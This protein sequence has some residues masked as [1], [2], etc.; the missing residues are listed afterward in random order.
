M[1][2]FSSIS[3]TVSPTSAGRGETV[4]VTAHLKDIVCD[5]KNVLINIPQYGLTEIM[6]EQDENTYVLSYMIPWDV[7]SGS[8]TVNVYVMDQENKKSSTGSFVYTVK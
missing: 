8:Y 5:V 7:L 4:L 3:T 1:E 6:K 2:N